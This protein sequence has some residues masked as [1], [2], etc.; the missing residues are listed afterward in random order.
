MPDDIEVVDI[1]SDGDDRAR[2]IAN[3]VVFNAGKE[4]AEGVE[5]YNLILESRG[6]P[7]QITLSTMKLSDFF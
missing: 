1:Y 3:I 2:G 6:V 7:R 4:T 5:P